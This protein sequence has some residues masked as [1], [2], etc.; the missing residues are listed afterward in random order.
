MP[1]P[2]RINHA[3]FRHRRTAKIRVNILQGQINQ[4][5]RRFGFGRGQ[6]RVCHNLGGAVLDNANRRL[7][8]MVL[9]GLDLLVYDRFLVMNDRLWLVF[10][11]CFLVGTRARV[12]KT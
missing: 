12:R 10:P 9:S 5:R 1:V 7:G 4:V 6:S 3:F 8:R 2:S 11:H